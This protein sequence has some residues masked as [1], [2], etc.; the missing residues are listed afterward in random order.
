MSTVVD[1]GQLRLIEEC[2][3]VGELATR[4]HVFPKIP[5][6]VKRF[7][8]FTPSGVPVPGLHRIEG[9]L[10]IAGL[11]ARQALVQAECT[12]RLE[13][14]RS[15]RLTLVDEDGRVLAEGH[16]PSRCTCC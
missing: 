3:G 16:G 10:G 1:G 9:Q 6:E 2:V 12:L 13:D 11:S 5:Y 8:A 4:D 14:G 7:Q 15:L